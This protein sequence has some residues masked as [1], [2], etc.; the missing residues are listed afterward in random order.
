MPVSNE[1]ASNKPSSSTLVG[2]DRELRVLRDALELSLQAQGSLVLVSGE[3]GIGK[4]TLVKSLAAEAREQGVLVLTGQAFDLSTTPPYG[5]WLELTDRFPNDS[6]LPELPEVLKRGTGVG[7]LANQLALFET[8]REFLQLVAQM[9]PLVL[10]LE[11][12]HW[13]DRDS[14]DL[15]RYIARHVTDHRILIVSTYRD[16]EITRQHLL[17]Q[18][19]PLLIRETES[20]RVALQRLRD[21]AVRILVRRAYELSANDEARL[22]TY[23]RIHAE[24]NPLFVNE[25]LR[26]LEEQ[27]ILYQL[28]DGWQLASL[29][30]APVPPLLKQVVEGRL[31]RL[32]KETRQLL[33]VA[34]IIGS[35]FSV[36]I[37][38]ALSQVDDGVLNETLQ[39][40]IEAYLL[41]ES[42]DGNGV[43]FTHA[44]IRDALHS[45]FVLPRRRRLH[46]LAAELMIE[47]TQTDPDVIAYHFQQ[48]GDVRAAEWLA[49]AGDQAAH[50]SASLTAVERFQA[51][52]SLTDGNP[53]RLRENGWIS[54]KI[55]IESREHDPR[56]ARD[57]IEAAKEIAA[58]TGDKALAAMT[59]FH[60]GQNRL[61]VGE[62][63]FDELQKGLWALQALSPGDLDTI[64]GQFPGFE[65]NLLDAAQ[66]L[67][68]AVFGQYQH[69][70]H[71]AQECIAPSVTENRFTNNEHG[72]AWFALALSYRA[73][74][75][76]EAA[77][78]AFA[79]MH[80]RYRNA[81]NTWVDAI[82]GTLE[83]QELILVYYPDDAPR[84]RAVTQNVEELW[85]RS[86]GVATT[87]PP[88]FGLLPLLIAEGDWDEA[89]ELALPYANRDLIQHSFA[90]RALGIMAKHQGNVSTAWEYVRT[91]I[92]E[93]PDTVPGSTWLVDILELHRLAVE[94]A[95]SEEQVQLARQWLTAHDRWL[96]WSNRI[97][98]RSESFLLWGRIHE[99][100][101]DVERA[102][103]YAHHALTH[104]KSPRQPTALIEIHRYLG[105]LAMRHNDADLA[106]HHLQE[107]HA[108]AE[109][110]AFPFERAL[111]LLAIAELEIE[112]GNLQTAR[113][114]LASVRGICEP[115]EARPT[116]DRVTMLERRAGRPHTLAPFNLTARELEVLTLLSR[117]MTDRQIAEEL[118]I[119][120]HTVMRHVSHIL[121]K[122]EVDSRAA[123]A[124]KAVRTNLA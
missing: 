116:L 72:H 122:L 70:I 99:T 66:A 35:E 110:C 28:T 45:S 12:M 43:R 75:N 93:G 60:S 18:M 34:A 7:E 113:D 86:S 123:A 29:T 71:I 119:S 57:H 44:L 67:M 90:L 114:H 102:W 46:R 27:S 1:P 104:A 19:L 82:A 62:S 9:R 76:P 61:M 94:L 32:P 30:H 74:G 68:H 84:R 26:A 48:A 50:R 121:A 8:V 41:V 81:G 49:R 112:R 21:D 92:P 25:L 11:D 65:S 105:Y 63:G 10:V 59:S 53:L 78:D 100:E 91:G 115:L 58:S 55:A 108:L 124:A 79:N 77:G 20:T 39:Q 17:F 16:D 89:R 98:G 64:Q 95:L 56:F 23:L 83:L 22:S 111:T 97:Q 38:Q 40:A 6:D 118:F 96:D 13:A 73:L 101:G 3:A 36:D 37:W 103:E 117:G 2:R 24:G 31:G 80:S 42:D 85:A 120:R 4:T 109:K 51:A 14:L 52:L 5:P 87:L 54:L 106:E 47:R 107:S 33:Q 88:K 69:A 15:L